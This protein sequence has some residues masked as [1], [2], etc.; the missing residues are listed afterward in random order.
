MRRVSKLSCTTMLLSCLGFLVSG[1]ASSL[2]SGCGNSNTTVTVAIAMI[3]VTPNP[4]SIAAG[5]KQQFDAKATYNN[6][7][8]ADISSQATWSSSS[9]TIA[10]IN[11]AGMLTAVETGST[12]ITA[13][14]NGVTG[15]VTVTVTAPVDNKTLTSIAVTPANPSFV[16]GATQQFTATGTYSDGTTSNITSTVTW[17]TSSTA[18]AT[19]SAAGLATG[20]AAGSAN[21]TA[22]LSGVTGAAE[23][24]VTAPVITPTLVSIA[25]TPATGSISVGTNQQFTAT[26]TYSDGSTANISSTAAWSVSNPADASISA[27]GLAT[28]VAAGTTNVT[29]SLSGIT[30]TASLTVTVP[31][32]PPT[33]VSVAVTPAS[34]SIAVGATQQFTATGTYADGTTANISTAASWSVS[35][36]TVATISATGL[37]T[38][39]TA[40]SANVT[41]I[42]SGIT[43]TAALTVTAPVKTIASIAVSPAS[44]SFAAGSTQQFTATATYSDGTTGNITSTATWSTANPGVATIDASGLATG[45]TSGSTSVSA[46]QN[47]IIGTASFTVTAKVPK[48]IAVTPTSASIAVG[49][50][51]Q[52]TATA[53]YSDGTTGNVTKSATWTAAN[54]AVATVDANGLATAV[55]AGSTTIQAALSG[56]TSSASLN[57]TIATS[58]GVNF[59]TWHFDNNRSGL[60]PNEQSLTPANV[61]PSTFGKLFSYQ[62]D[63]YVYG[64]PLLVSSLTVNGAKHNVLYVATEND[65]VYAFDADTFGTGAPLWQQTMLQAGETP[66]IGAP[67][68][69]VEGITSTPVIDTT[70]NTIYVVSTQMSTTA[71]ASFRLNALDLATGAQ[72]PGS[73]VTLQAS[74][75]GTGNTSVN[76]VVSLNTSCM[77][78]A[79]LLLS[80]NTIYIGFGS[81]QRGW[82]L[83]YDATSLAQVGVFNASPNLDGEGTYKSAGGIWMGGG[84]PAADGSGNVYAVTG[85]GPWDGKTAWSDTILKFNS[86]LQM[87]DYFTPDSYQYMDCADADLAAGGLLLLPG[88][89]E[90]LVGGKIGKLFLVNTNNMGHETAGDTGAT[91]TLWY[92]DDLVKPYSSSCTDSVGVNTTDINPYEIFGTAAYFNGSVYLGITPTGVNVPAGIRQFTYNGTLTQGPYTTPSIQQNTRGTTPFVSANGASNG[93]VWMIDAGQPLQNSGTAGTTSAILRAYDA[94][95]FPNELYSSSTNAADTAGYGIKFSSPVVANGKV[96]IPTGHDLT[97]AAS[98]KGEIDVYGLK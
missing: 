85:N 98:P 32:T 13:S 34:A 62:V 35:S 76:G 10:T 45:V 23:F 61:A 39:S 53:T 42:V 49:A 22:S 24:N 43:G 46:S 20:V 77:Q 26:G 19:I 72:K 51:Q 44:A 59:T 29:A 74:M 4:D 33:L 68:K 88:T 86:K 73:P 90:A 31:V 91:Q 28:G 48:S 87:T 12:T 18:T 84:G 6:G 64:S 55:A 97:T 3:T 47:S 95:H 15:T 65:S 27:T 89:S 52:Y 16:V 75:P 80:S 92:E 69:P 58:T 38:G 41:A 56:V 5:A 2:L 96:Y 79:A 30:G 50:K 8:T 81:C 37:A 60:N 9:A 83:A 36:T 94:A 93:I 11:T 82:L 71:P 1:V 66:L 21:V 57:V 25:L 67:I 63:G 54:S 14:L 78:R 7:T 17:A 40:G 70:T